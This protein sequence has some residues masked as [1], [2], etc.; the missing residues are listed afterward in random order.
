MRDYKEIDRTTYLLGRSKIMIYCASG[1][2]TNGLFCKGWHFALYANRRRGE[3]LYGNYPADKLATD[4]PR[5]TAALKA[6]IHELNRVREQSP[7]F[8]N[9][10]APIAASIE[11]DKYQEAWFQYN[12]KNAQMSRAELWREMGEAIGRLKVRY[13][14]LP[15]N[16]CISEYEGKAKTEYS[17]LLDE[18]AIIDY[19][20]NW[21]SN[22]EA[23]ADVT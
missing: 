16:P 17:S 21:A 20:L 11:M 10:N 5:F 14:S 19:H 12:K 3:E 22:K 6:S 9:H 13:A 18:V 15:A 4:Y 23:G 7:T 1:Y 8:F 2:D